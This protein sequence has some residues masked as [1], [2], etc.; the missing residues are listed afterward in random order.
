MTQADLER[1]VARCT[2]ETRSVIQRRGFSLEEPPSLLPLT[3]DWDELES[4]RVGL[5]PHSRPRQRSRQIR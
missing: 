2:G 1:E 5:L 3:V 4:T